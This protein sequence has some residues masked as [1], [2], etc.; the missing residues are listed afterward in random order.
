M[1]ARRQRGRLSNLLIMGRGPDRRRNASDGWPG[2][3]TPAD[4][5]HDMNTSSCIVRSRAQVRGFTL[6]E[7]MIVVAIAGI[8]ATVAYPS[9]MSQVR[10]SRRSD[11]M[12]AM[13]RVMQAQER[14]RS[15]NASYATNAQMTQASP[16]GL[17]LSS[18]T[19]EG[20]FYNLAVATPTA[21][22][23]ALT[24]TAVS[25]KSQSTDTGCTTMTITVTNGDP[26]YTPASCWS[27]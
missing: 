10:K 13:T 24:A 23:Y 15:N 5:N 16:A 18:P 6:I 8:L 25:G 19:T 26:A 21:A 14:W 7:L 2:I 3:E 11:A 27:K 9:Y 1:F 22:G 17:G 12:A 20:G 4:H